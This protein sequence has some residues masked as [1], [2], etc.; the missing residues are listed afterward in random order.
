MIAESSDEIFD[1]GFAMMFM[2]TAAS[3]YRLHGGRIQK[4]KRRRWWVRP[5]LANR[6]KESEF[7]ILFMRHYWNDE[8]KFHSYV[9]MSKSSFLKLFDLLRGRLIK[10]GEM[11]RRTPIGPE[12]R[13][14]ATLRFLGH[15]KST[16]FL[17]KFV[18]TS[19]VRLGMSL[20]V[21]SDSFRIAK[22]TL[23]NII[24]E[25]C[26]AIWDILKPIYIR[27]PNTADEWL[28]VG[29]G[30][31]KKWNFPT[32]GAVDG[33]HCTIQAPPNT[34]ALY[35]NYK[36]TFSI[37]L[38]AV[39]DA[40]YNYIFL[41]IGAYGHQNDA[42]IFETT[43]F[44]KRLEHRRMHLP[45]SITLPHTDLSIPPFLVGDDIF[46]LKTYLLKPF[47][48]RRL[49]NEQRTFNYRLSRSRRTIE[50]TFGITTNKFRQMRNHVI[51]SE[52]NAPRYFQ[53][54]CSLHN[55]LRSENDKRYF[56]ADTDIDEYGNLIIA[57]N[58]NVLDQLQSVR[59]EK[60]NHPVVAATR[61][62]ELLCEYVNG[63]GAIT[64][65][66]KMFWIILFFLQKIPLSHTESRSID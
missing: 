11:V 6:R 61:S 30:F 22:S 26:Q 21:L 64:W 66:N 9:R 25:T 55:F 34:G 17:L 14:V 54:C 48:G 8:E 53:A 45:T 63:V 33:K 52:Q 7:Y 28:K 27:T 49:S 16:L 46:P 5:E 32:M 40:D 62:R 35:H 13:L 4:R 10:D 37:V 36:G 44:G 29:N 3:L 57:D 65:Q 60:N 23:S 38:M 51:A 56:N 1:T 19:T 18:H 41:D 39:C 42:A 43:E 20:V 58:V 24:S 50:N 15:G 12:E 2:A 31:W 59:D 47:P